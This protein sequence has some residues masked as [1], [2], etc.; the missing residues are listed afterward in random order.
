MQISYKLYKYAL[1]KRVI[2][3]ALVR[4]DYENKTMDSNMIKDNSC[5]AKHVLQYE[6]KYAYNM[7]IIYRWSLTST[8]S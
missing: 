1:P 4:Y 2:V 7:T 5:L 6:H 8:G 3:P